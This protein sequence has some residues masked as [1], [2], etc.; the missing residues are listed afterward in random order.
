MVCV[1]QDLFSMAHLLIRNMLLIMGSLR[2]EL[3]KQTDL[4]VLCLFQVALLNKSSGNLV[5]DIILIKVFN[6]GLNEL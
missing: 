3:G 4:S 5:L 1:Y 6:V 2:I